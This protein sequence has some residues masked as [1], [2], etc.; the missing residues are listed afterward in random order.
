V[1][2]SIVNIPC[3]YAKNTKYFLWNILLNFQHCKELVQFPIAPS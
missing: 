1:V 3:S 2:V